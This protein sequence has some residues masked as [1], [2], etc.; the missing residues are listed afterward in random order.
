[1][2]KT[3]QIGVRFP[4]D[5]LKFMEADGFADSPQ[6]AINFLADFY[7]KNRHNIIAYQKMVSSPMLQ[8][9]DIGLDGTVK[10]TYDMRTMK[11]V[12]DNPYSTELPKSMESVGLYPKTTSAP[13]DAQSSGQEKEGVNKPEIEARIALLEKELKSPP[14][15]PSI[16]MKAWIYVRQSEINKLRQLL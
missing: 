4:K 12:P 6:K 8:V 3:K 7:F 5:L 2:E 1:M 13:K 9:R 14:P 16:G 10:A 15:S 11:K